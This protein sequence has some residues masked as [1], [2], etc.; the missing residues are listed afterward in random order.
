MAF[1][2]RCRVYTDISTRD[3]II[4]AC[5]VRSSI[6]RRRIGIATNV[7]FSATRSGFSFK[8]ISSGIG[9]V[10]NCYISCYIS[11]IGVINFCEPGTGIPSAC[12][13]CNIFPSLGIFDIYIGNMRH[14]V[15]TP[16]IDHCRNLFLEP[17]SI[18]R[19]CIIMGFCVYFI[20]RQI[21]LRVIINRCP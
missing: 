4:I 15:P 5:C 9:F 6:R 8:G 16:I 1:T 12:M 18:S 14:K 17:F 21:V 7:I 10:S 2:T 11:I 19:T 13:N 20:R 3:D